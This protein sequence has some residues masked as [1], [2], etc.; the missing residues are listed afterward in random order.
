MNAYD[1]VNDGVILSGPT[2]YLLNRT[3][4]YICH[5][6]RELCWIMEG[7]DGLCIVE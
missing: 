6:L 7:M 2:F 5:G 1:Y 4:V 3:E